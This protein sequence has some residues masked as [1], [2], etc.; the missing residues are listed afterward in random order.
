[1]D[2]DLDISNK[3]KKLLEAIEVNFCHLRLCNDFLDMTQKAQAA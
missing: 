2:Q 3:N 1:M